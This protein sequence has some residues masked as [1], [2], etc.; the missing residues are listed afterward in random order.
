MHAPISEK[1]SSCESMP[2]AISLLKG[3]SQRT[4]AQMDLGAASQVASK[5]P[6]P[7]KVAILLCTMRGERYLRRQ[8]DSIN[9]QTYSNW[10]IFVSD[11]GSTDQTLIIL[12]EYRAR[13][14]QSRLSILSG[15]AK[16]FASNFLSLVCNQNIE[17]D[18]FAYADQDDIWQNNKLLRAIEWLEQV[19]ADE[20]ALYCGR[21]CLIDA[22]DK[23][24]GYAPL[25]SKPPS[26]SNALVQ[27]IGGGNTMVFNKEAMELLRHASRNVTIS[28]HDWW[29]Y[30]VISGCGG[31]VHYDPVPSVQY[32]QHNQNLYGS[33]VGWMM[34]FRRIYMLLQG[35]FKEWNTLN[36]QALQGMNTRLTPSNRDILDDF[37]SIRSTSLLIRL[38]GLRRSRIYRQTFLGNIGLAVAAIFKK[39]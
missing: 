34:S 29:T 25:F 37:L 35:R 15:P 28:A 27:N 19:P 2:P 12:E 13:W 1:L 9:A 16:G 5:R 22:E 17:A 39:I 32:R 7:K 38:S 36:I 4:A 20:P 21:T 3:N 30:L 23:Q 14:G 10:E 6:F 11:D 18:Y 31:R 33:N 8:L 26:F 24:I